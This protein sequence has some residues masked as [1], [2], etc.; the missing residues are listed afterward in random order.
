MIR[1]LSALASLASLLLVTATAAPGSTPQTSKVK[2]L[3]YVPVADLIL[4]DPPGLPLPRWF[5][6][7]V[8]TTHLVGPPPTQFPPSPC[9]VHAFTWNQI[10][11]TIPELE[12]ANVASGSSDFLQAYNSLSVVLGLMAI[13]QCNLEVVSDNNVFPARVLSVRPV[14]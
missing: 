1:K 6:R 5:Q 9:R 4:G 12:S 2:I 13:S 3:S 8:A 14:P 11:L 7:S 10:V